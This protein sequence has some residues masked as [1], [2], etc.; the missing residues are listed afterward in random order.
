MGRTEASHDASNS[1]HAFDEVAMI[2]PPNAPA[3]DSPDHADI[4]AEGDPGSVPT[5]GSADPTV[6]TVI[7]QYFGEVR[8][9]A[10]LSF[11]E[12]QALGR[13]IIRGQRRVRWA[14]YTAPTA[15]LTLRQLWQEDQPAQ[16]GAPSALGVLREHDVQALRQLEELALQLR[17]L[18]GAPPAGLPL[19]PLAPLALRLH[20]ARAR[21]WRAWL[22][23]W[24]TLR[25]PP[26]ITEVLRSALDAAWRANP[27]EPSLHAAYHAWVR[28]QGVLDQAKAQMMQA[29]LRL[30]IHIALR[31]RHRGVPLLDLIQEGNLGLMRAV[32][33][34]EPQRGL[35]FVTYAHW[36]IRQAIGRA[37]DE[38]HRTI[39]LPSHVVER[40][41]TLHAAA[42]RLEERDGRAP[43][44]EA[45]SAALGWTPEDVEDLLRVTQPLV[46][47]QQPL[48]DEGMTLQDV[49]VDTETP[50]PDVLLATEQV[51]R[52]VH[53]CLGHLPEREAFILRL[54]YGLE[55][56]E[57]QSLQAIG[58]VLG[59][60]RERVRQL[61]QQAFATL[62][63]LP[64]MMALVE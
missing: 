27:D 20:H 39:R 34:F 47:L 58:D 5:L 64:Q 36:W 40:Q 26:Q 61:E 35:R 1:T 30:V 21:L 13:R 3:W 22:R 18:D 10:L 63:Q 14:L 19:A 48:R 9:F 24:N 57:P 56:C 11:A 8:R 59:V 12:E 4:D 7:A 41:H 16:A 38:Q 15:L 29:N 51:R 37:I 25:L 32:D 44:P 2:F 6:D 33:K 49:L 53:A 28:A 54:R 43:C 23:T 46:H 52:G 31:Y 42:S 60:S 55:A 50:P 62:R 45:L 17:R